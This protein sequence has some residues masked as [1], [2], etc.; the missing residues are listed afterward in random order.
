L[1]LK[2]SSIQARAHGRYE[3]KRARNPAKKSVK[4]VC[5]M[6]PELRSRKVYGGMEGYNKRSLLKACGYTDEELDRPLV[7]VVNSWNTIVRAQRSR[8]ETLFR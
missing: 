1:H 3:C 7:A 4:D 5:F 2:A 8:M 6:S